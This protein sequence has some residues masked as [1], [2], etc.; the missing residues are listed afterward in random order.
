M[1]SSPG[2]N[3]LI[4]K[5]LREL[6]NSNLANEFIQ[7]LETNN[8]L[9]ST[10]N[11]NG[12]ERQIS[13]QELEQQ[14]SHVPNNHLPHLLD[15][16]MSYVEQGIGKRF[17][18]LTTF[19]LQL[20]PTC[21]LENKQKTSFS[22]K[23]NMFKTAYHPCKY[24]S[25]PTN[26]N[27]QIILRER[28]YFGRTL[29]VK[30]LPSSDLYQRM[31]MRLKVIAHKASIY[32][33][34]FDRTGTYALSGAD[35]FLLKMWHVHTGRLMATFRGHSKEICDIDVNFENTLVASASLDK[36]V[37]VWNLKTTKMECVLH[38]H[39]SGINATKFSPFCKT[40]DRWLASVG[41]EGSI[42][43]WKYQ[44]G[45]TEFEPRPIKFVEKSR[46]GAQMLCLSFSP[47]GYFVAAGSSDSVIRVYSF[48]T[49]SP[50]KIC[51]LDRHT[52]VVE[53]LCY[54]H[55]SN[56]FISGSKDGTAR[57][58]RYEQQS[59]RAIV[60]NYSND[61]D[62]NN[63][64]SNNHVTTVNNKVIP[65]TIVSWSCTDR[66]VA[67]AYENGLIKIW[68]PNHGTLLNEL[69]KHE[70]T[71]FVLECHPTN[72]RLLCSAGHDGLL[73]IWDMV[74]GRV[75]KCFL[76]DQYIDIPNSIPYSEAKWSPTYDVICTT[77]LCGQICFFGLG[78]DTRYN[79]TQIEQFFHNDLRPVIRDSN[80]N[81]LDEQQQIPPH[82]LPPPYLIDDHGH[83]YS[84]EIQR[85]VPG[86]ENYSQNDNTAT[87][88]NHEYLEDLIIAEPVTTPAMTSV[89][90]S[91]KFET[92]DLSTFGLNIDK[93]Q[94]FV[95]HR[96]FIPQLNEA[97]LEHS[98][99]FRDARYDDERL[100]YEREY[101]KKANHGDSYESS[102]V[103]K[104][105]TRNVIKMRQEEL[106]R[107]VPH[108]ME[109]AINRLT[110]RALY[111]SD[112][113]D[114]TDLSDDQ[115]S[116]NATAPFGDSEMSGGGDDDSVSTD[117]D[118]VATT[119]RTTG[120][121]TRTGQQRRVQR[122]RNL[123]P[124]EDDDDDDE[125]K[126]EHEYR[127]VQLAK[128]QHRR[129]NKLKR[130]KKRR[131]QVK[132][133]KEEFEN[134][135]ELEL[136]Y[137]TDFKP[138]EWLTRT[139]A[140]CS[141]YIPQIG[142]MVMYFVQGHELYINEVKDKKMYEIDEKTLPWNKNEP[143]DA[144][145]CATV[146]GVSVSFSDKQPPRVIN[147]R[148]QLLNPDTLE[149]TSRRISVK[150]HDV[151]GIADFIILKQY[152]DQAIKR[153][154]TTGDHFRC[155]ID[156]T[157]WPGTIVK[158]EAFDPLH[159]NSPFQCYIIRWDNG[160]NEERLSP[161]DI[162]ECDDSS[163][164]SNLVKLPSYQPTPDE[165][166]G[167]DVDDERERL[168][169]GIDTLIQMDVAKQ[170]R[171]PVQLAWYPVVI[172]YPIDLG[173]IR[174]RLSNGYYRRSNALKWDVKK[175]EENAKNFNEKGSQIIEQ[176]KM[177]TKILLKYIDDYNCDD[178]DVIY[179]RSL[180]S[181]QVPLPISSSSWNEEWLD[182]Y[183]TILNDILSQPGSELLRY[184]ID[185]NEYPDYERIIKTPI[186]FDD[187]QAKLNQTPCGYRHSRE[188][189]ADCHLIFQNAITYADPEMI[190]VVK[191][192]G[193]WFDRRVAIFDRRQRRSNNQYTSE[194]TTR[195]RELQNSSADENNIYTTEDAPAPATTSS[196]SRQNRRT[197]FSPTTLTTD[198]RHSHFNR[199]STVNNQSRTTQEQNSDEDDDDNESVST[200]S[201]Q[202]VSLTSF[203]HTTTTTTTNDMN[204]SL[205]QTRQRMHTNENTN[206][207]T[208]STRTR[209]STR[210]TAS[211]RNLNENSND[212]QQ[213]QSSSARTLSPSD[214]DDDDDND[215]SSNSK[216]NRMER[217]DR[218]I[219][220]VNRPNYKID[221]DEHEDE[222]DDDEEDDDNQQ[223][224]NTTVDHQ[225]DMEQTEKDDNKATD[226]VDDEDYE[227]SAALE[228]DEEE[229]EEDE[230][231]DVVSARKKDD[232]D[233]SDSDFQLD[234]PSQHRRTNT[235]GNRVRKLRSTTN[236]PSPPLPNQ[237][238]KRKRSTVRTRS[239]TESDT[240]DSHANQTYKTRTRSR[241][242]ITGNKKPS[243]QE[244]F[245][246]DDDDEDQDEEED[247]NR[248]RP[249][250]TQATRV[251]KR[252][253]VLKQR[254]LS[255]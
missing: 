253:R 16:V 178:I 205:R 147:V 88:V 118:L 188:F 144:V 63:N 50:L 68:E 23:Y 9:P 150:F 196:S 59:W 140:Q 168:L 83:A 176:V 34:A 100:G 207:T 248:R 209:Y 107:K 14:Y 69:K 57:I 8:L 4:A 174:E 197:Q 141:P 89:Y 35:D 171:E 231:N 74:D 229:E 15:N 170:F 192:L 75:I 70:K 38:G 218:R 108:N 67:T 233:D 179:Q 190:E 53:T 199:I 123:S 249:R 85:S 166:P 43:F 193:P 66:S 1:A 113:E 133:K 114:K 245:T 244:D 235:N 60:L 46:A 156:D 223:K 194:M 187:V 246:D 11:W 224:T 173:T 111:D 10:R 252:G 49:Y 149:A 78:S 3:F 181:E 32:C 20:D 97:E 81:V 71:V 117:E 184:P 142:D 7:T 24:L 73:V 28:E 79:K 200:Q 161:W 180:H 125:N 139:T 163:D 148:L 130:L 152:Y 90:M 157:W 210:S 185:E 154:W 109:V 26:R 238:N 40:D 86:R 186:C 230:D 17:G 240:T 160:E 120:I 201:T 219:S 110:T 39:Q 204:L 98:E 222:D 126:H 214:D 220:S 96:D 95:Y 116:P 62:K 19:L 134:K 56:S 41:S 119:S 247:E 167:D 48:H 183:Q 146:I 92:I 143:L 42:C 124:D 65:V 138:P 6:P 206:N 216:R 112:K 172:A 37:R 159:E 94:T 155:F 237:N 25:N 106:L 115:Y 217:S 251:S 93:K 99:I 30:Q 136:N 225:E 151:D 198:R 203:I 5:Y 189:I 33:I 72:D 242:R 12:V 227:P 212:R 211:N 64:D 145:E 226:K 77:D 104:R 84:Y 215:I 87:V 254:L 105:T 58:W 27:M 31:N 121:M 177:V 175:M 128:T 51:E 29:S 61:S 52:N 137:S 234:G 213:Q 36:K 101:L 44:I 202:A 195:R 241:R 122:H 129:R 131:E 236:R 127:Q 18:S 250:T 13:F 22:R 135:H 164:E 169:K 80:D 153:E 55:L 228:E 165:W 239:S 255:E 76:N 132:T 47:G 2:L 21:F 103:K 208:W 102:P 221:S 45:T 158:R 243:L 191:Q 82:L 91:R 232:D 162:F 54:A 182:D